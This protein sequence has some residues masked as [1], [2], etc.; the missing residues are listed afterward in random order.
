MRALGLI[1]ALVATLAIGSCGRNPTKPV[2]LRPEPMTLVIVNA[3]D[4]NDVVRVFSLDASEDFGWRGFDA[5]GIQKYSVFGRYYQVQIRRNTE[6][7]QY[8][9]DINV[10]LNEYRRDA[11]YGSS[12]ADAVLIWGPGGSWQP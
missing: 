7:R 9:A 5:Q 8:V 4:E 2:P 12:I 11:H 10:Q 3:S 6:E 1:C